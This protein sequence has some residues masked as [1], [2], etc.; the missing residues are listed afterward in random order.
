ML[1]KEQ[2]F[3]EAH[4]N[5]IRAKYV[6]KEV[7][8]TA[9]RI[10]GAYEDVGEAYDEAIKAAELGHFMIKY[11]P[12]DPAKETLHIIPTIQYG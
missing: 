3:Y 9:D 5:E 12:E 7:V 4:R 10:I 11:I 1:E 8:L 2:A 6:G